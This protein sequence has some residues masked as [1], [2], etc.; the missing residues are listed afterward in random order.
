VGIKIQSSTD[1][2]YELDIRISSGDFTMRRS[3]CLLS[4]CFVF[5]ACASSNSFLELSLAELQG[6]DKAWVEKKMGAPTG[7]ASRF[8]GGETWTYYSI[9]GGKSGPPL[10]NFAPNQCQLTLKFDKE[11]KVSDSSYSGC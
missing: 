9:A 1:H 2:T 3:A 8:F 6:K 10:F 5:T 7:K 4:L 11:E